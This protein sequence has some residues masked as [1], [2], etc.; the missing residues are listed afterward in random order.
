MRVS[1]FAKKHTRTSKFLEEDVPKYLAKYRIKEDKYEEQIAN[2]KKELET[3]TKEVGR[4]GP[5]EYFGE[6]ALQYSHSPDKANMRKA[7]IKTLTNCVFA[8]MKKED[9]RQVLN[10]IDVR[11]NEIL[12]EFFR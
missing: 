11:N 10:K 9:Y 5:G 3:Y 12:I 4:P 7:T 6:L 1:K 8:T 2:L